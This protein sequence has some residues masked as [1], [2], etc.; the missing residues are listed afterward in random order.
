MP[1][2]IRPFCATKNPGGFQ[3]IAN[4]ATKFARAGRLRRNGKDGD[5]ERHRNT[6]NQNT[7]NKRLWE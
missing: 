5:A 7:E 2:N 4:I 1:A 6:E 3:D